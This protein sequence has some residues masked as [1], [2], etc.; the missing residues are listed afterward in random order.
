MKNY[1]M[2]LA[3]LHSDFKLSWVAFNLT[4]LS[5]TFQRVLYPPGSLGTPAVT[6]WY[7]G[8]LSLCHM[9]LTLRI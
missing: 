1:V 5:L 8:L 3:T 9:S 6:T 4:V 2:G 7:I